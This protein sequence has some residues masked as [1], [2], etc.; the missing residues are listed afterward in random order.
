MWVVYSEFMSVRQCLPTK[1]S[2]TDVVVP[3]EMWLHFICMFQISTISDD[4]FSSFA[5]S[6]SHSQLSQ[7]VGSTSIVSRTTSS[8]M[9]TGHAKRRG[10]CDATSDVRV[11]CWKQLWGIEVNCLSYWNIWCCMW[12]RRKTVNEIKTPIYENCKW[13]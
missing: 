10:K 11:S 7:P 5:L 9:D 13:N 2:L 1:V 6:F 4:H 8:P 12:W 3:D